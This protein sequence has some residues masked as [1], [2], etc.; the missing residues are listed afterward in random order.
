MPP[1]RSSGRNTRSSSSLK[2]SNT[3]Q[4]SNSKKRKAPRSLPT[5][6]NSSR[7][8]SGVN[9]EQDDDE[10]EEPEEEDEPEEE[11][12]D[13]EQDQPDQEE[14]REE[15]EESINLT[16]ENFQTQ[17]GSWSIN[18]LRE[19]L[20]KRKKSCSNRVPPEVQDALLLLQQNY[21]KSKLMLSIIGNI[22]ETTTAKYL[23]ENKP[24]LPPK[25]VSIGWEERNKILGEAWMELSGIEKEVFSPPIFQFFSKIPCSYDNDDEDED[26]LAEITL[27]QEEE[28]LYRP[29]YD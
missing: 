12:P 22:T 15:E 4:N 3:K 10:E 11:Q 20:G 29:L 19:V 8:R 24:P 23:G 17:L 18:K 25:G 9:Q 28:E 21:I 1:T 16:L 7:K 13:S 5:K 27:T 26:E 14:E 6:K 2:S